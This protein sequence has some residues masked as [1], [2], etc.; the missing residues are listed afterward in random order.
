MGN[1]E[2]THYQSKSLGLI[3]LATHLK[4]KGKREEV[5]QIVEKITIATSRLN[6]GMAR[7]S[8]HMKPT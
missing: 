5:Y 7:S 6:Q 4:R 1:S 3:L 8:Q 2:L